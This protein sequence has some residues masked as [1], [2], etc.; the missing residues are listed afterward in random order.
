MAEVWENQT[1]GSINMLNYNIPV[2]KNLKSQFI[3]KWK[4]KLNNMTSCDVYVH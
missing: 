2:A 3:T 1:F 4:N